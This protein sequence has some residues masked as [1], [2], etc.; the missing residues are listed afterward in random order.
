MLHPIASTVVLTSLIGVCSAPAIPPRPDLAGTLPREGGVPVAVIAPA[1]DPTAFDLL[2]ATCALY[3]AVRSSAWEG[4][5]AFGM[6]ADDTMVHWNF[7]PGGTMVAC[8]PAPASPDGPAHVGIPWPYA[9]GT[10]H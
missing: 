5:L 7:C 6:E 1:P 2:H 9:P 3:V 8:A 10:S 4:P